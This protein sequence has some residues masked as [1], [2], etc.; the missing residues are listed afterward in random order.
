MTS[1]TSRSAPVSI[2]LADG[3]SDCDTARQLFR[4]YAAWLAIDLCFQGFDEE[5][6]T[7]P[8]AY[9]PP[10]GRLFL[11][12]RGDPPRPAGCVALRPLKSDATGASCELKRLWVRP[13]FRG[14]HLGHALTEAALAAAR[15]IGYTS[16]K[17]DTLPEKMPSAV[18]MYRS[19][20]FEECP[21]YY[22]NPITG[23]LY[24]TCAL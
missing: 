23:S 8:G 14:R 4:E 16:M 9:A 11:A 20:G 1:A 3:A 24:M 15:E 5:L 7:L 10:R 13:E 17:L 21:P 6:A 19:F 12:E 18:A 22:H 2:R